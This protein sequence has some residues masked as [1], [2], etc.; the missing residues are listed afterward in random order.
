M[1]GSCGGVSTVITMVMDRVIARGDQ[2]LNGSSGLV[3]CQWGWRSGAAVGEV[4]TAGQQAVDGDVFVQLIPVDAAR[5]EGEACAL[6]RRGCQQAGKPGQGHDKHPPIGE[7]DPHAVAVEG[8]GSGR[9]AHARLT[10]S[11]TPHASAAV[12]LGSGGWLTVL[13]SRI[14]V[15]TDGAMDH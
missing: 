4:S 7:V 15:V 11:R 14:P 6:L 8:D 13:A 10:Q 5:A 2:A 1:S 12:R 3:R 9:S